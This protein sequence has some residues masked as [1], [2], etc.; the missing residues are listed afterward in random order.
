MLSFENINISIDNK[1]IINNISLT[2][3]PGTVI[4]VHGQNGTGKTS[5]LN[6]LSSLSKPQT[7]KIY[8]NDY[9]INQALDEYQSFVTYI[10]HNNVLDEELT[11][12]ENL[13]FW[14]K[15]RNME[16]ALNA[17]LV[18][19]NLSQY[20]NTAVSKLSQGFKKKVELTK[21][22]LTQTVIWL[23]D[24]PFVNLDHAGKTNLLELINTKAANNGIIILTAQEPMFDTKRNIVNLSLQDYSL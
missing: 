10:G 12:V 9:D 14:A 7:G 20:S 13:R 22:L 24:E 16:H 3:F 1:K 23:L 6:I 4:C 19:F 15:I 11:V 17:S 2:L 5:F 18:L 8:F 21:L